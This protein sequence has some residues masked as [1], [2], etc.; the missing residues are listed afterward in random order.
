MSNLTCNIFVLQTAA[1][2]INEVPEIKARQALFVI[3]KEPKTKHGRRRTPIKSKRDEEKELLWEL[4]VT[5]GKRKAIAR[6]AK[7]EV[8]LKECNSK[9]LPLQVNTQK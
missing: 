3:P 5:I 7:F 4:T 8:A 2:M 6:A 9:L 1:E